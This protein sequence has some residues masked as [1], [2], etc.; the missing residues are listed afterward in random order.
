M[1]ETQATLEGHLEWVKQHYAAQLGGSAPEGS[2][3]VLREGLILLI[4]MRFTSPP[5][6]LYQDILDAPLLD[7]VRWAAMSFRVGGLVKACHEIL[8]RP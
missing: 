2:D 8:D 7:V 1:S 6:R 3:Q 4:D 5:P